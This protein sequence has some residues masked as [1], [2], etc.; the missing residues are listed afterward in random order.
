MLEAQKELKDLLRQ[1]DEIDQRIKGVTEILIGLKTLGEKPE[2][3]GV[4][5]TSL[6][7]FIPEESV[8]FTETVRQIIRNANGPITAMEIRD[9]LEA[10]GRGGKTPK[11]T[12]IS[13]YTVVNR[14][15]EKGHI[16]EVQ[17]DGKAAYQLS[18]QQIVYENLFNGGGYLLGRG[19]LKG[20]K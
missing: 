12:L 2:I 16:V 1:R 15:K 6:G 11:H 14:L 19:G 7:S 5:L 20:M 8:G 10:A 18:P 3:E 9:E 13:V 4:T 17:R